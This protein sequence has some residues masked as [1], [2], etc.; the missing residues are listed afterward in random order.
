MRASRAGIAVIVAAILFAACDADPVTTPDSLAPTPG[1]TS[2]TVHTLSPKADAPAIANPV[3]TFYAK[4]GEHR[5]AFMYYRSRPG[6]ADSVDFIR[7]RVSDDALLSRPDGSAFAVGDSILITITLVDPERLLVRFEPS[8]LR[9][10][11]AEPADLKFSF[12]ETDEDRDGDGSIDGDD[13]A[14]LDL[15]DVWRRETVTSPWIRQTSTLTIGTH[16]IETD[17]LG[18]TDYIIAW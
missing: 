11:P 6:H 13:L 8:G 12:L 17:V 9:F 2:V 14:I 10:N 7:F 15:L 4:L 5:E 18:F 1:D 3:V 16:E